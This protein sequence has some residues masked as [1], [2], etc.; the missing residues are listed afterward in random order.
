MSFVDFI[1]TKRG[2]AVACMR[3]AFVGLSCAV[4]SMRTTTEI[5]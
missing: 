5:L 4:T 1:V 2:G 3:A